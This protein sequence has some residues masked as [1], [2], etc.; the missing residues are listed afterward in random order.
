MFINVLAIL[1][2]LEQSLLLLLLLIHQLQQSILPELEKLQL[3]VT[4]HPLVANDKI[5]IADDSLIFRCSDDDFFTEQ[6]YPR[7][8]DP[9]S[10][11]DLT[12]TSVTDNTIDVNVGPGGGA[13]TGAEV[14]ATVGVGGTLAF[15]IVNGGSGY[16]N[17]SIEIPEPVY[18]NMPVKG[19]SR[20][21]VGPTTET[22]KNLAF[23]L[24]VGAAG[25]SNV[26]IGST[27]FLIDSFKIARNGYAFKIGDIVEVVGLVTAK[28]LQCTNRT[29]PD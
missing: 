28:D 14:T 1:I 26:G 5:A 24:T 20:L 16:I 29:I 8:T 6:P 18:E 3:T 17:P 4:N 19:V 25:T 23:N 12:I 7:S 22:G 13:G 9:A 10:G 2:W 27:L 15:T 21:G 11:T